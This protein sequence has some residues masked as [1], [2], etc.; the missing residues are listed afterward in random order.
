MLKS[1]L[2]I[3][4]CPYCDWVSKWKLDWCSW[5]ICQLY[6]LYFFLAEVRCSLQLFAKLGWEEEAELGELS[7][8]WVNVFLQNMANPY[9]MHLQMAEIWSQC[10]HRCDLVDS[11][12]IYTMHLGLQ[13]TVIFNRAYETSSNW[14]CC[15]KPKDIPH[16]LQSIFKQLFQNYVN[17]NTSLCIYIGHW[18]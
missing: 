4:F 10:K 6:G 7:S 1:T 5:W 18:V 11:S 17:W 14:L 15:P 12:C 8:C 9:R 2:P 16:N 13:L 3:V